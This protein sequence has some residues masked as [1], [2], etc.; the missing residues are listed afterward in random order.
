MNIKR[1][2]KRKKRKSS[3][4]NLHLIWRPPDSDSCG[5]KKIPSPTEAYR[6]AAFWPH[7]CKHSFCATANRKGSTL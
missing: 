7:L 2:K 1:K 3:N 4:T 6:R 5:C